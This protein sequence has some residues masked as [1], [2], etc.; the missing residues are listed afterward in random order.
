MRLSVHKHVSGK[1]HPVGGRGARAPSKYETAFAGETDADR[2]MV[3]LQDTG[4]RWY[5]LGWLLSG[6][7]DDWLAGSSA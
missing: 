3:T 5:R 4:W 1:A 6:W 2:F 7:F